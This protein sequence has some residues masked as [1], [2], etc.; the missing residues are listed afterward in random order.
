MLG[1]FHPDGGGGPIANILLED[2]DFRANLTVEQ[3]QS[4]EKMKREI[5]ALTGQPD[6]EAKKIEWASVARKHCKELYNLV[7]RPLSAD[8]THSTV[9]SMNRHFEAEAQM[10]II[11]VRVAPDVTDTAGIVDTLACMIFLWACGP[12]VQNFER[13]GDADRHQNCLAR[14]RELEPNLGLGI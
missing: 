9:D 6:K 12:F 11:A 8:G 7:Y 14:F 2:A 4:L 10:N 1:P 3:V 5:V 13:G